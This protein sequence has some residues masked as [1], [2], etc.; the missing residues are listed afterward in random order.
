MEWASKIINDEDEEGLILMMKKE[1]KMLKKWIWYAIKKYSK[2]EDS[3]VAQE[4]K[5]ED[6]INNI[7]KM[8]YIIKEFYSIIKYSGEDKDDNNNLKLM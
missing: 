2:T 1:L 3:I 8:K 7:E 6:L 5:I 4:K